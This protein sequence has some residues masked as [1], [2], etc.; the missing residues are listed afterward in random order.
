MPSTTASVRQRNRLTLLVLAVGIAVIAAVI[1]LKPQPK[2]QPPREPP[3]PQVSVVTAAPGEVALT[4]DAQGTATAKVA[5]EVVSR[6]AG[7]VT[8]VAPQ[9]TAGGV[10]TEGE[11][12]VQIE[13]ADYE[14]AVLRASAQLAKAQE[15]LALER[16]RARQAKRE[17][18]DLGDD[19][20]NAL[21]LREPQLAAAEATQA[22]AEADLAKAQLDLERTAIR[23]PFDGRIAAINVNLGQFVAAGSR[24]A[25]VLGGDV[26]LLRLPL[27]LRQAELIDLPNGAG[28]EP[29]PEVA[30]TLSGGFDERRWR[31][32]L[33]R[34][35]AVLDQRSRMLVAVVEVSIGDGPALPIGAFVEAAIA[36]RTLP[37]AMVLPQAAIYQGDQVLIVDEQ[38]RIHYRPVRVLQNRTETVV[39]R[40]LEPGW[41]VVSSR[42]SLA[43]E[44]QRVT[45][46]ETAQ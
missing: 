41:R 27:T 30:I 40:G 3:A 16:G 20:A 44:G 1:L 8:A 4:I 45:V 37:D 39:V 21:F 36:G 14:F 6:V 13:R 38:N 17:W 35:E 10:F 24:V 5:V 9:F 22:A 12:L 26:A 31:G 19:I 34:T 29:L 15:A 43:I 18:R 32:Q 42:L 23:L 28:D 2:S 7:Q 11:R 46:V 25:S 33:M